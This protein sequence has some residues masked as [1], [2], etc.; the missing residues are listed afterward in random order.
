MNA[1]SL[2]EILRK[3]YENAPHGEAVVMIHLFGI[4]YAKEIRECGQ[5]PAAIAKLGG[6]SETYGTEINKAANLAKYVEVLSS[7]PSFA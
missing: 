5:S 6:I 3:A 1:A 7:A 4:R 2:A